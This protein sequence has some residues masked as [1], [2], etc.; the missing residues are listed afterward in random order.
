M[1]R[2]ITNLSP[3]GRISTDHQ[4]EY[5]AVSTSIVLL[6]C[7]YVI[8]W[9]LQLG[10]RFP[11]LGTI[12]FEF[13]YAALL[14]VIAVFFV[15]KNNLNSPLYAY[16]A[17]LLLCMILQ[18]P[19][20]H[21]YD[22]SIKVFTDR[23]IKFS[24][25]ALF[26][27]VF[28][29]SPRHLKM[30]LA[31]FLLVCM[32]MGQEGLVGTITGGLMWENQG[33]M[34]L[35]GS[36]PM[37]L[38]PNSFA[39]NALGSLPFVVYLFPVAI[40]KTARVALV[41]QAG[42][43]LNIIVHAGSRTAYMGLV[44]GLLFFVSRAKKRGRIIL[45]LSVVVLGAAPFVSSQYVERF[46]SIFT[47]H[48]KEGQSSEARIEI[49]KD[50]WQIL[51]DHPF[52]VG[53]A[54]FPKVRMETFGREQDTHNLYFEI[55]TNLGIQGLIVF[56]LFIYKLLKTLNMVQRNLSVD[57]ER[58]K[59]CGLRLGLQQGLESEMKTH[60]SDLRLMD[61]ACKATFLFIIIR[62]VLGVFGMDM[63]EIYWWFGLGLTV[64]LSAMARTA[65][66]RTERF[67]NE[68][69]QATGTDDGRPQSLG[70]A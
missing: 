22:T 9:Y 12:R 31:A 32:K 57:I 55:A 37:Y 46:T 45:L 15:T 6:F 16:A 36:T 47:M 52:G 69:E 60:L 14:T 20:S 21:D 53:V 42:L 35:H 5:P 3:T 40:S 24:F 2:E 4:D 63:Y 64:A 27:I 23:V 56:L 26:I 54:A 28:V 67:L 38:H 70:L 29:R 13:V 43:A 66:A 11:I 49:L 30:F 44:T 62:L 7:G 39:G 50:A 17:L 68:S 59:D 51:L 10:Y 34:R 25:V 58:M 19:F 1:S 8:T 18:I 41:A 33:V 48:E 65:S 61:A